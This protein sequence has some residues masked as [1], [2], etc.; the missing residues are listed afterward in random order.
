MYPNNPRW[1]KG[2]DITL[3]AD[4]NLRGNAAL[5][6]NGGIIY[7]IYPYSGRVSF[8][9]FLPDGDT[10]QLRLLSLS[11]TTTC[12]SELYP[13]QL[14][15]RG[16]SNNPQLLRINTDVYKVISTVGQLQDVGL[17]S[18]SLQGHYVLGRSIDASETANWNSGAGF[19]PIGANGTPFSGLLDGL[20]HNIYNLNI[21]RPGQ[22][23]VGLFAYVNGASIKRLDIQQV[24][25]TGRN[26][27][28]VLAGVSRNS[29]IS[30]VSV[31]S[32]T[33]CCNVFGVSGVDRV[34]GLVGFAID[35]QISDIDLLGGLVVTGLRAGGMIG[36]NRGGVVDGVKTNM[37]F[38]G[39]AATLG[40]LIGYSENALIQNADVSNWFYA[41]S[42]NSDFPQKGKGGLVGYLASGEI[43]NSSASA[44]VDQT[45]ELLGG[46]V[47]VN[48]GSIIDSS[49]SLLGDTANRGGGLVAE[50]YGLIQRS[51]SIGGIRGGG[52]VYINNGVIEDSYYST[53]NEQTTIGNATAGLVAY[54]NG[55]IERSYVQASLKGLHSGGQDILMGGLV[56][57]N[58]ASGVINDSWM[59]GNVTSTARY[60]G[61]LVGSNYGTIKNSTAQG[62]VQGRSEVGGAVGINQAGALVDNVQVAS[63]VKGQQNIGGLVGSNAE[64]ASIV[65]SSTT[66][67]ATGARFILFNNGSSSFGSITGTQAIGGLAGFN[68][69]QIEQVQSG[70]SVAGGM[71][72]GG[73]AGVNLGQIKQ[74][75]A[76]STVSGNS[77]IGGL[78]GQNIMQTQDATSIFGV[79]SDSYATGTVTGQDIVGG[80][81]GNNDGEINRSY[82]AGKVT[83]THAGGLAGFANVDGV[84]NSSY[85]NV[86]TTGKG[87][88]SGGKGLTDALSKQKRMYAGWDISND[89][90]GSSIWYIHEG[91]ATPVLRSL[92]TP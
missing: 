26:D 17:N 67:S 42:Q 73:L 33:G 59:L 21:N 20:G 7:T 12:L 58:N 49:G 48:Y 56:A 44:R 69:G 90:A 78:V 32:S 39:N 46:L 85:W 9:S 74:G 61:G 28:G 79:I 65:N 76:S 51:H 57:V 19:N 36:Y 1:I 60:V 27:V 45:S 40:G 55:L 18:S 63:S 13:W 70:A 87:Q 43:R 72:V 22:D 62:V 15:M 29:T 92:L 80:L 88:S 50:N 53:A 11:C 31:N 75:Y 47:G 91:V 30:S 41:N 8:L 81:A 5:E 86:G 37:R 68:A 38:M 52:L 82:A 89:L 14:V 3:T 6:A 4:L 71:S 23:R 54:N 83:G 25:I 2:K 24:K 84:V 35:S 16:D 34:G 77:Y 66:G 10:G 64:G